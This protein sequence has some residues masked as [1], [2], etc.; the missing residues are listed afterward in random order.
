MVKSIAAASPGP[1][2][3]ESRPGGRR[4]V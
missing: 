3:K 1:S 2:K 4:C